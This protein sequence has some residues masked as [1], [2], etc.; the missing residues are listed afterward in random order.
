MIDAEVRPSETPI[1]IWVAAIGPEGFVTVPVRR[2]IVTTPFACETRKALFPEDAKYDPVP[3]ETVTLAASVQL[4][5]LT[6]SGE[7]T[8]AVGAV[9]PS[10]FDTVTEAVWPAESR[11]T[12]G[13]PPLQSPRAVTE[14]LSPLLP[15]ESVLTEKNSPEVLA[16]W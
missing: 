7:T 16:T 11:T 5:I 1:E 15:R 13:N 12:T 14:K 9:V 4:S 6:V 3:P 10:T 8:T 2:R